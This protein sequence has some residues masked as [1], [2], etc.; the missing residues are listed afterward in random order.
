[1]ERPVG[2]RFCYAM[3]TE[4]LPDELPD[5]L[6]LPGEANLEQEEMRS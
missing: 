6:D 1:M 2:D 5:C 3:T 4:E